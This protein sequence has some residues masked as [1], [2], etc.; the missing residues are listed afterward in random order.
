MLFSTGYFDWVYVDGNHNYEFVLEDLRSFAAKIKVGGHLI[1]DDYYWESP[2]EPGC[3]PVQKAVKE[4]AA[5]NGL[6][7]ELF[8]GQFSMQIE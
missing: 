3:F 5:E 6:S 8:G 4:F 7:V 2:E 1:G